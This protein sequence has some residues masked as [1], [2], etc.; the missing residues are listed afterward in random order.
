[1]PRV[2]LNYYMIG[3]MTFGLLLFGGCQAPGP[4]STPQNDPSLEQ[5]AMRL[6]LRAAQEE[7]GTA[8]ANAIE[9]LADLAPRDNLV[10]FRAAVAD[11]APLIRF[12]G[13]IALGTAR[14]SA[15]LRAFEKL[16]EIDSDARVRLAAAFAAARCGDPSS[17][18]TL[19]DTLTSHP[20]ERLRADAAFLIGK[21]GEPKALKRLRLALRRED[22]GYVAVQIDAALA[23]L[24][25]RASL[26]KLVQ[27]TLKS[28]AVTVLL[29]LQ[30]LVE[31]ADP[32]TRK[33]LEYRLHSDAD[34]PQTRLI[35]ARG[36]GKLGVADGYDLALKSLS[37]SAKD[38]NETMQVR[39]NA[40]MALGAIGKPAALPALQHLAKTE[41]DPRTQVAAA[42]AICQIT[43]GAAR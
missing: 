2:R 19:V 38:D 39:V 6:L 41:T 17:A 1:M 20:D 13:C 21:L 15:S 8:R 12:A 18:R 34:Y 10:I 30:T 43:G 35:A 42:Y 26:D 11:E 37:F 7:I 36:L 4:V 28:D 16:S 14:D 3:F 24:G 23:L 33:T 31:L 27:Y 5:R 9:A 40:A 32:T 25:D 29:A 22:S